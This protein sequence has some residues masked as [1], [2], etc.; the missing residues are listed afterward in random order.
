M[1]KKLKSHITSLA[2]PFVGD[3]ISNFTNN[4]SAKSSGAVAAQLINKSP[5][6]VDDAPSQK[7]KRNPLSFNPVQ[8][9]LDLGSE[10]LG[11]YIIFESGFLGYSPQTSGMLDKSVRQVG[12]K[13]DSKLPDKSITTSAVAIYMPPN[14]TVNYK[15]DYESDT[16]GIAG[17]IEAIGGAVNSAASSADQ[18]TG[19]LGGLG[20]VAMKKGKELVGELVSMAGAG[21]P[22]RFLAKR[23]GA[24]INPRNEQF[25]N[26]PDFRTFTYEFDFWPRNEKEALA[27]EQIVFIF[28]Y[29]SSPGLKGQ[30]GA[31][32]EIPNYYKISYM[33][34]TGENPHLHKISACYCTGVDVNYSPDGQMSTFKN[35]QPTHTKLSLSFV[36]DR[37]ITKKDIEAGA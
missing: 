25:Y 24:A 2:T 31:I 6:E 20:G 17:D 16:A 32:F 34:N 9:P 10:E 21:D 23:G 28:K 7:L 5:F 30:A 26:S 4:S 1:L 29:N 27:V 18:I 15:Q 12:K 22:V 37:I 19:F 11:H 14:V 3:I 13:V 36:E 8:Y 35:G 33:F